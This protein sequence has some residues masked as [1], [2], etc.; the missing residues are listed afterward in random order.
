M[1]TLIFS[2]LFF[3]N[4]GSAATNSN[5]APTC[6]DDVANH[7]N[8]TQ[9][10]TQ[11]T[12]QQYNQVKSTIQYYCPDDF[13]AQVRRVGNGGTCRAYEWRHAFYCWK[14]DSAF[15]CYYNYGRVCYW[16]ND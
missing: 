16:E 4:L 3:A 5:A 1:K 14:Q 12:S 13:P 6:A 9:N 7:F 11:L 10:P 2:L 15:N 8:I